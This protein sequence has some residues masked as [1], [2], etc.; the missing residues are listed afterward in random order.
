MSEK[1]KK[2][3]WYSTALHM[4]IRVTAAPSLLW[5]RPKRIYES[6]KAKKHVKGGAL[7]IANHVSFFDPIYAM[8]VIW[9]RMHHFICIKE[10]MANKFLT[11][12]L[13][14]A[15]QCIPIDRENFGMATFK[16]ITDYIESGELVS[17]Y[18]EG[19]VN[20]DEKS[21]LNS[22]KSGMV[23]MALRSNCPIIPLYIKP[24]EKFYS[25]LVAVIGEPI[26]IKDYYGDKPSFKQVQEIADKLYKKEA[27]LEE[28]ARNVR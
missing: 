20:Q 17:M 18:P 25:R 13:G 26:N 8:L 19:H 16:E 27:E 11:F 2:R 23:L 5:F 21:N 15:C 6:E 1:K 7:L 3:P 9:Y 24:R 10:L 28:M 22:F 12:F 4:F 14:T